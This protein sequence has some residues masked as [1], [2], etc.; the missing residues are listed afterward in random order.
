MKVSAKFLEL[1]CKHHTKK[2][3]DKFLIKKIFLKF[4]LL[5]LWETILKGQK[6]RG[7]NIKLSLINDPF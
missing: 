5:D 7:R 4:Y 3:C 6:T 1:K 2:T